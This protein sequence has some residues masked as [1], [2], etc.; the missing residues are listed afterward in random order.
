MSMVKV[1]KVPSGFYNGKQAA[2]RLGLAPATFYHRVK[3]GKIPKVIPPGAEKTSKRPE[4][5]Y[6]KKVIDRMAQEE[7]LFTLIHSIE[8]IAFRRAENEN[9]IRGIVDMCIAFYGQGNTPSYDARLEIW[10]KNPEVYYIVEQEGIVTG[11]ISLIWFDDE[12]LKVLMG[13]SPKQSRITSAGTGVYSVTGPEHV[14]KFVN[15][16]PIESLFISLGVRPGLSNTEQRE[17]SFKLLRGTQDVLVSFVERG[18]PV[19][20]LFATSEKGDGIRLAQKIGMTE[21]R[22]PGDNIRR[23]ELDLEI[24]N[25]PLLRS[26]KK[27]L[28]DWRAQPK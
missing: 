27:A 9:D 21:I 23:Y 24:C 26:Y 4:G 22:Y 11:Y 20:K 5:Y 13:P 2:E 1:S 12:A 25:H 28:A 6:E 17:Y 8:P 3:E 10:Q 19:H 18:M 15:G 16:Q 14:K 7:A